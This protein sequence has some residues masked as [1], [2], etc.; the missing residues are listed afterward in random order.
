MCFWTGLLRPLG[1]CLSELGPILAFPFLMLC[2]TSA[3]ILF[4]FILFYFI[5][6][7]WTTF[8]MDFIYFFHSF[9]KKKSFSNPRICFFFGCSYIRRVYCRTIDL[10]EYM[11]L[12]GVVFGGDMEE[13]LSGIIYLFIVIV[14]ANQYYILLMWTLCIVFFF[15]PRL[16]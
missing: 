5:L 1:V 6:F 15:F 12:M 10:R 8:L 11:A 16:R 9:K 3:L 14:A 4:Y 7:F 13:K 2:C